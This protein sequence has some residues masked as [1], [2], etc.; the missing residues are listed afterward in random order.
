MDLGVCYFP[1]DYGIDM[2]ELG[3]ALE[4]RGFKSLFVPE[5]THIPLSRRTPF[6][7]G[8]ELPRRYSHTHDPFVALSF[9]AAATRRLKVGTGILLVP[10][11]EPI[12]TAKAIASLDQLSG[13][14]FVFGIG[15]GWNVDEM[16]N[17]GATHATRFKIM[18]EHVL[19]MKALWTQDEASFHGEFVKF[20][21]TWSWPKPRQKPYPPI[22]LGGETDH[23]LR[24]IIE[25]CDGWL[26]RPRGFDPVQGI[27][28]MRRMASEKKRDPASL[29]VTV[30]AAPPDAAVLESYAKAGIDG[31][32]LA[33]PDSS[34]DEILRQLDQ[35]APLAKAHA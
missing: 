10:Q 13:G 23:T 33:I 2:T 7:G 25:Y 1:T 26:P 8:G 16:E 6:P 19:A 34:R 11:H 3:R 17:H 5:H 18:R 14:R 30:F 22:L 12:V 29:S 9:A 20:D 21:P 15:G 4:E 24:R 31:A 35:W 32:L 28:R 27:D